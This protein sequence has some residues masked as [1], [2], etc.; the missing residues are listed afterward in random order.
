MI[1]LTD[2]FTFKTIRKAKYERGI[3]PEI[4][5]RSLRKS[6]YSNVIFKYYGHI[7]N[8][9]DFVY[10]KTCLE[11]FKRIPVEELHNLYISE[12]KKRTVREKEILSSDAIPKELKY[13]CMCLDFNKTEY[14]R[15]VK[16]LNKNIKLN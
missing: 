8:T 3:D 1:I 16:I 13:I 7:P 10:Y 11:L 5:M 12:L 14:S 6:E 15:L 9:S 4:A 2:R